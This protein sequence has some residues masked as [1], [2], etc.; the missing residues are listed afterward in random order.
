MSRD[1][2][3]RICFPDLLAAEHFSKKSP[4]KFC[5]CPPVGFKVFFSSQEIK[6]KRMNLRQILQIY[7]KFGILTSKIEL[8][9]VCRTSFT[10]YASI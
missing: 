1:T 2:R 9:V 10:F 6:L 8:F 5:M 3:N 4:I 7:V